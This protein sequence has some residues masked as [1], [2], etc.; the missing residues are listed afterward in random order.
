MF[1]EMPSWVPLECTTQMTEEGLE[2]SLRVSESLFQQKDSPQMGTLKS[3]HTTCSVTLKTTSPTTLSSAKCQLTFTSVIQTT[4]EKGVD[5]QFHAVLKTTPP[6]YT[7]KCVQTLQRL[8]L[9]TKEAPRPFEV[10][11]RAA[12]AVKKEEQVKP[13]EISTL[14]GRVAEKREENASA[15]HPIR[16]Q[17]L[18]QFALPLI[19]FDEKEEE[20]ERKK[21]AFAQKRFSAR[22]KGGVE[23]PELEPPRIG[24][25]ALYY[26]LTKMGIVSDSHSTWETRSNIRQNQDD[27]DA[28]HK[29]RL[30]EMK[31]AIAAEDKTKNWSLSMQ[32]FSW[33][34]SFTAIIT[35]I[36]L[37]VSGVGAIAGAMILCSGLFAL[38][39]H[40]LQITGGWDKICDLLPGED[41]EK[42]KAVITWMQIGISV[43]CLIMAGAGAY[44]G[45]FGATFEAM[46]NFQAAF[47]SVVMFAQNISAIGEGVSHYQYRNR[48]AE[49][50]KHK[51]K[52]EQL[53]HRQKDLFER[54][55]EGLE[56]LKQLF[57]DLSKALEFET[58]LFQADQMVTR[59]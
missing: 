24:I 57:K 27:L 18:S 25:F 36:A 59:G 1:T 56:R 50:L 26:V 29:L 31:K 9:I 55:E 20:K 15:N 39:N 51:R 30:E 28:L 49:G 13:L 37:I 47:G 12:S 7:G 17:T 35:G 11:T 14:R 41:K 54:S 48:L 43:L 8:P 42:K 45:G 38:T 10:A 46:S 32:V 3:P 19:L 16:R 58:E 52:I 2:P 53:K 23:K 34:G 22:E 44:F 5:R 6:P 21:H 33:M 4:T 40:I